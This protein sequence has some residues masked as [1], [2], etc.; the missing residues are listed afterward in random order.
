MKG[1]AKTTISK[2]LWGAAVLMLFHMSLSALILFNDSDIIFDD[3]IK[4]R[5][6]YLI[7]GAVHFLNSYSSFLMVL[8]KAELA[9]I[10]R[11]DTNSIRKA[12]KKAIKNM[13]E[14]IKVYKKLNQKGKNSIYDESV[15][16]NLRNFQYD[17]LLKENHL[18]KPIFDDANTYLKE[19]K[20]QDIYEELLADCKGILTSLNDMQAG[21]VSQKFLK[22]SELMKLNQSYCKVLLVGQYVANVFGEIKDKQK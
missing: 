20:I 22:R 8:N 18:F 2:L 7:D 15:I 16:E 21:I 3:E 4:G 6:H 11:W 5:R 12:L 13:E 19:G 17:T 10:K 9:E 1:F 14:A